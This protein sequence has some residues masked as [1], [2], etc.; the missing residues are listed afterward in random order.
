MATDK[1][2]LPLG[3]GV[4]LHADPAAM[5]DGQWQRLKNL[6]Q[7][8]DG[9]IGQRPSLSFV[10][11]INPVLTMNTLAIPWDARMGTYA[12]A[13][14][15]WAR[16]LRPI[17]FIFDPNFGE[18]TAVVMTTEATKIFKRPSSP[19][20]T[21]RGWVTVPDGTMLVVCLPNACNSE[22]AVDLTLFAG[23]LGQRQQAP[24]I[25]TFLGSTY[26]FAGGSRGFKL[27]PGQSTADIIP[28]EAF[29]LC[30]FGDGN[31]NF[32]PDGAAVVRDRVVYYI[33]SS[34]F[35]SDRNAPLTVGYTG[36]ITDGNIDPSTSKPA[37]GTNFPA[38]GTRDIY[39]GGDENEP[40]TAVAEVS[41][42]A[43]G[44]PTQAVTMAFTRT[45]AYMLIGEPLETTQGG[46]IV[47]SL[48]INKLNIQCGCIAQS[49]ICRTPY[50][51]LWVGKDDV[52][53]MPF[54]SVPIPVGTNI[55]PALLDI[56]AGIEWKLHAEYYDNKYRISIPTPGQDISPTSAIGQQYWLDFSAGP[57]QGPG[58]AR[59]FGPQ[60]FVQG[61]APAVAGGPG[62]D[63]GVWCMAKDNRKGGDGKLYALQPYCMV[64][65]AD[66]SSIYGMSLCGFDAYDGRDTCAPQMEHQPWFASTAY[67]VNAI[68]VPPPAQTSAAGMNAPAYVCTVA[69]TSDSTEPDWFDPDADGNVTDGTVTWTAIKFDKDEGKVISAHAPRIDQGNNYIEWS[70]LS[71]EYS[72]GDP[73][74]EKLLDGAELGYWAQSPC[75]LTY[76]SHPNQDI[77]H[78]ILGV[79]TDTTT[80]NQ[81][82]AWTGARVW[83]RKSLTPDPTKRFNALTAAWECKHDAGLI[84]VAGVNDSVTFSVDSVEHTATID[85]GYYEDLVALDTAMLDAMNTL[86]AWTITSTLFDSVDVACYGIRESTSEPF[87]LDCTDGGLLELFGFNRDQGVLSDPGTAAY[88]FGV[89]SPSRKLAPP[90][91]LSSLNLRYAIFKRGPT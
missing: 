9:I 39:L 81:L 67:D 26:V 42:T 78:K 28:F 47:G 53:F 35:W 75:Y 73:Q 17:K 64:G 37:V 14:F 29:D 18:I 77:R 89:S 80:P 56:P 49:T 63:P 72:L 79:T 52:W 70:M 3:G 13:Y 34:I 19:D 6:A 59:W 33:G 22:D 88:L 60:Q 50:G 43:Q 85:A 24:S 44:S 74:L 91:Q 62:G 32:F 65:G 68:V 76:N 66:A 90:M 46:D 58:D 51:T 16:T 20:V 69:G 23:N 54:G 36:T 55:R 21:E 86:G 25:I 10:R 12:L 61:D 8:K 7:V 31:L 41:T 40:I 5:Q 48:H 87:D 71:K 15:A 4:N 11:E 30:D 45:S 38:I 1:L 82:S 27:T 2:P 83:Q 57:P 84:I